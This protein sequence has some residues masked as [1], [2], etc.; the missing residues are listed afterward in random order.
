VSVPVLVGY[1]IFVNNHL[2]WVFETD[3]DQR[4]GKESAVF[5]VITFLRAAV[6]YQ[7]WNLISF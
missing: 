5:W 1:L 2:F 7:N 4:T 3:Q 6:I